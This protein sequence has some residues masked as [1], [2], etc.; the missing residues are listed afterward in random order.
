MS[1]KL[2]S[3]KSVVYN[4]ATLETSYLVITCPQT[5]FYD[6]QNNGPFGGGGAEHTVSINSSVWANYGEP[7]QQR[8]DGAGYTLTEEQWDAISDTMEFVSSGSFD[9]I[10]E[11]SLTYIKNNLTTMFGLTSADWVYSG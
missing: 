7:N 1:H 6:N 2:T 9:H 8:I 10:Q 5:S 3:T 11:T 4:A